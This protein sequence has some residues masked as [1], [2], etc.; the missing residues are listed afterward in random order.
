MWS[1]TVSLYIRSNLNLF[2][3]SICLLRLQFCTWYEKTLFFFR[4]LSKGPVWS[5]I[6]WG[7]WW[8]F[9]D[10]STWRVVEWGLS[11]VVAYGVLD[12]FSK[13]T[14]R[15]SQIFRNSC[16]WLCNYLLV[17]FIKAQIE[18]IGG[19]LYNYGISQDLTLWHL[20]V[21]IWLLVITLQLFGEVIG[22]C[23]LPWLRIFDQF[24]CIR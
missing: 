14:K 3:S 8:A 20:S 18:C 10:W 11:E 6:F 7:V 16:F 24:A 17:K 13:S 22:F 21:E 23:L 2:W 19:W 12:F 4:F 9:T 1:T 5:S 15:V